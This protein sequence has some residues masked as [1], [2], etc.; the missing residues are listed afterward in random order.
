MS[1]VRLALHIISPTLSDIKNGGLLL[2]KKDRLKWF[3]RDFTVDMRQFII[4]VS[5][6]KYLQHKNIIYGSSESHLLFVDK[7]KRHFHGLASTKETCYIAVP[8]A[9]LLYPTW[10]REPRQDNN[11]EEK[12]SGCCWIWLLGGVY[13]LRKADRNRKGRGRRNS[14]ITDESLLIMFLNLFFP[15]NICLLPFMLGLFS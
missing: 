7:L 4:R 8:V 9:R 14:R 11:T 1:F 12:T 3:S 15:I 10:Y 6:N 13:W 2:E 5:E